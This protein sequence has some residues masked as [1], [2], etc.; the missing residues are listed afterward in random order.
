MVWLGGHLDAMAIVGSVGAP[1]V[2]I[3]NLK[4][5][6]CGSPIYNQMY[7]IAII[8]LKHA[9]ECA[10]QHLSGIVGYRDV[11]NDHCILFIV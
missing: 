7:D 8:L 5:A 10:L 2:V 11:S 1:D 9:V 4:G 6:V 3:D